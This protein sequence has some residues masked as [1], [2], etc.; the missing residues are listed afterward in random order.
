MDAILIVD[1]YNVIYAWT[2]LAR[3]K[4]ESLQ[5][6]R[7]KLAEML[8]SYGAFTGNDVIIVY[9][10][11]LSSSGQPVEEEWGGI[12]I[13]YTAEGQTADSYIERLTYSLV[14]QRKTVYV[15]TSDWAEQMAVLGSG[16]YRISAAELYRDL[17]EKAKMQQTTYTEN[18]LTYR[19]NEVASRV[20]G[21]VMKKLDEMRRRR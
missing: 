10:A 7:D 13:V 11:H 1:G 9:D 6:A 8:A 5:H 14:R 19:R 21:K 3:L 18:P 15:V 4:D 2:V 17:E 20:G 16:A 12:T